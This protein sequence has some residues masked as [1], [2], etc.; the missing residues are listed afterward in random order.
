MALGVALSGC[1]VVL[2]PPQPPAPPQGPPA[3]VPPGVVDGVPEPGA[4][5]DGLGIWIWRT[6]DDGQWHIRSAS[7]D[8]MRTFRGLV[9]GTTS[10][11][12]WYAV[13]QME[14][15]DNI[16]YRGDSLVFLFKT[17][18]H[19]DGF[20]FMPDD[21]GCVRF[22]ITLNDTPFPSRIYLGAQAVHPPS[23]HFV[24]CPGGAAVAQSP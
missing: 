17:G 14:A 15:G 2:A 5:P 20:D 3:E 10:P 8:K 18:G 1:T 21:N 22:H 11:I 9:E 6:P 16:G 24:A 19:L 23:E 13:D 7:R 12:S 4:Q